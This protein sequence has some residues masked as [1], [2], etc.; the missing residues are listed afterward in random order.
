MPDN[1]R[2]RP[3]EEQIRQ[4]AYELFSARGRAD[5]KELDDW[6]TAERELTE[7]NNTVTPKTIAARAS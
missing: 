4:R 2:V 3:S 5:G 1:N 7:R 6:L